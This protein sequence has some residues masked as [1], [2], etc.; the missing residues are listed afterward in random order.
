MLT[1]AQFLVIRDD[2]LDEDIAMRQEDWEP[3]TGW[4]RGDEWCPQPI[5]PKPP[6]VLEPYLLHLWNHPTNELAFK[7]QRCYR[8][9]YRSQMSRLV[10]GAHLM[11][12]RCRQVLQGPTLPN[13]ERSATDGE[14]AHELQILRASVPNGQRRS[15]LILSQ[16]PLKTKQ[17]LQAQLDELTYGWGI[18]VEEKFAFPESVSILALFLALCLIIGLLVFCIISVGTYGMGV[19]GIW[20]GTIGLC[21]LI[22]TVIF[23]YSDL[24][25]A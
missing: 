15:A 16:S 8:R 11:A 13:A 14:G 12:R 23:K 21:G 22:L 2:Q 17:Q 18:Y 25:A 7:F 6:S 9:A 20:G 24:K 3:P 1:T 4:T 19:F 10:K 5:G